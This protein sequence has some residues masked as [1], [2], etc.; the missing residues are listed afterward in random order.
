MGTDIEL[1]D[2]QIGK[3]YEGLDVLDYQLVKFSSTIMLLPTAATFTHRAMNDQI[4]LS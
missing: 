3:H 4:Y 1:T 2:V